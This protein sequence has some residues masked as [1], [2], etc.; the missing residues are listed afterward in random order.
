MS[1]EGDLAWDKSVV[2]PVLA[3]ASF[4]SVI[5]SNHGICLRC[6]YIEVVSTD[7]KTEGEV[8]VCSA[9]RARLSALQ[10]LSTYRRRVLEA[11]LYHQ[12]IQDTLAFTGKLNTLLLWLTDTNV[13]GWPSC[14]LDSRTSAMERP[15]I[16]SARNH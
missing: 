9:E 1:A 15:C 8:L 5:M 6:G 2:V 10:Q 7:A 16:E 14:S 4:L 13:P 12:D 3:V 11:I